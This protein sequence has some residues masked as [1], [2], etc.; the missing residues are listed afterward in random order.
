M[1]SK[2]DEQYKED[3]DLQHKVVKEVSRS[4]SWASSSAHTFMRH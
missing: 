3:I 1:Y 4:P 2:E